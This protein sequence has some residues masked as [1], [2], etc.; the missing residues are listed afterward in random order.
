MKEEKSKDCSGTADKI[1]G[2][3]DIAKKISQEKKFLKVIANIYGCTTKTLD[4]QN[5][6]ANFS[7]W[8][9]IVQW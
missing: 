9:L 8:A 6:V 3:Y 7:E 4:D 5:L 2:W 1:F